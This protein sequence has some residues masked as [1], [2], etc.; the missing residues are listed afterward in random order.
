MSSFERSWALEVVHLY[1]RLVEFTYS[2]RNVYDP[3]QYKDDNVY[4]MYIYRTSPSTTKTSLFKLTIA[5]YSYTIPRSM[6][7]QNANK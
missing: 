1:A 4:V 5:D 3:H 2:I 7:N 6:W